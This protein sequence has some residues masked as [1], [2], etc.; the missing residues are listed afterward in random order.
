MASMDH[1]NHTRIVM[2]LMSD[3]NDLL[4]V[5]RLLVEASHLAAQ[6]LQDG[7]YEQRQVEHMSVIESILLR[8]EEN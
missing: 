1:D 8:Y 7:D 3:G 2:D 4:T 6:M 5:H